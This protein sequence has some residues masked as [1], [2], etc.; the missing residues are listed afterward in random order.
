MQPGTLTNRV[1]LRRS[2]T[3]AR[4]VLMTFVPFVVGLVPRARVGRKLGSTSHDGPARS[5]LQDTVTHAHPKLTLIRNR[6]VRAPSFQ[7]TT[8]TSPWAFSTTFSAVRA[9]SAISDLIG[10]HEGGLGGLVQAFEKDGLGE[11]AQSWVGK[12]ANLPISAAQIESELGT[13]A[14]GDLAKKHGLDPHVTADQISELLLRIIDQLAPNGAVES[15]D[16][17]GLLGKLKL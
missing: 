10:G 6:L 15:G 16:L 5:Q 9:V 11:A 4:S 12:G 14:I 2:L 3:L 17:G 13:G 1:P 7:R 8:E